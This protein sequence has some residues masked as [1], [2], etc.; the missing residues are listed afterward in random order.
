[1]PTAYITSGLYN[2]D[3]QAA[4]PISTGNGLHNTQ[5]FGGRQQT[6]QKWNCSYFCIYNKPLV[7]SFPSLKAFPSLSLSLSLAPFLSLLSNPFFKMTDDT[8]RDSRQS[9]PDGN[10]LKV[11]TAN[12]RIRF[13]P[14]K[15]RLSN[16][17][18][19]ILQS[20][21]SSQAHQILITCR[22]HS[23]YF[24]TLHQNHY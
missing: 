16:L 19:R 22:P 23:L 6:T 5:Q 8:L 12:S 20:A 10:T 15:W 3:F 18:S 17:S 1:M 24:C 9:L 21:C 11:P 13:P 14:V 7:H 2:M 4:R